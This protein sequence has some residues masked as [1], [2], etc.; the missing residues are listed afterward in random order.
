MFIF[1]LKI[2]NVG[3]CLGW[4]FKIRNASDSSDHVIKIVDHLGFLGCS[5]PTGHKNP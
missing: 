5:V 2:K 3:D 1:I 4:T